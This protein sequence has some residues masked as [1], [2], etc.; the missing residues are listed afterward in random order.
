MKAPENILQEIEQYIFENY[1][2]GDR[3]ITEA[4]MAEKFG[5]GR[6]TI[7]ENMSVLAALGLII[8][9]TTGTY[10][11]EDITGCLTKPLKMIMQLQRSNLTSI[12]MLR[13][14]LE[15]N[16]MVL[17]AENVTDAELEKLRYIH[18]KLLNPEYDPQQ[19]IE[20]DFLFHNT[21]ARISGNPI[22]VEFISAIR[23]VL[24]ETSEFHVSVNAD[25]EQ[26]KITCDGHQRIIDALE[27]RSTEKALKAINDHF[28][29]LIAVYETK[30]MDG[31]ATLP[32]QALVVLLPESP[33]ESSEDL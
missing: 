14:I 7:R 16:A 18:W 24:M 20:D 30:A 6:S 13:N 9:K 3:I 29:D 22:L 32:R 26:R 17:A 2:A 27:E 28:N 21:I 23:R 12:M 10:V 1:K 19:F 15:A 11:S 4:E 8:R 33:L 25:P 5:V 31:A